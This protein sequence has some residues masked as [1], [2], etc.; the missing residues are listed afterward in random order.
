MRRL[1]IFLIK[2]TVCLTFTCFNAAAAESGRADKIQGPAHKDFIKNSISR[3]DF[4]NNVEKTVQKKDVNRDG[5]LSIAG[6]GKKNWT[7]FK[8]T[9]MPWVFS[10]MA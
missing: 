7:K 6:I 9:P 10:R 1:L 8:A 3:Q 5:Q 2:T 4:L